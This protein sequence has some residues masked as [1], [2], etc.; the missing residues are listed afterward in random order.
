MGR[1][2]VAMVRCLL[3]AHVRLYQLRIA[4]DLPPICQQGERRDAMARPT[5]LWSLRLPLAPDARHTI[6]VRWSVD[7][8]FRQIPVHRRGYC[9]S[10]FPQRMADSPHSRRKESDIKMIIG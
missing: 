2:R 1:T 3:V 6:S 10:V 7:G 8:C 9:H 4:L 5:E